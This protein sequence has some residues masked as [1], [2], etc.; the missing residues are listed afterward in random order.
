MQKTAKLDVLRWSQLAGV[1]AARAGLLLSGDLEAA[2]AGLAL[3]PQ[4]PGD[5]SPRDKMKELVAWYL[6]DSA[7]NLRRRIGVAL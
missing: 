5:L 1:S 7:A 6:G 2:R 4:A 3:E